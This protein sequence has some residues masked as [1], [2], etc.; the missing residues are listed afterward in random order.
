LAVGEAE[1]ALGNH[2]AALEALR[3]ILRDDA[4]HP[5][6]Y[7]ARI[8]AHEVYLEQEKFDDARKLLMENL[9]HE[10]LTPSSLEW[11]DSLFAL[12]QLP[13]RRGVTLEAAS[14]QAGVDSEDAS[15]RKAGLKTLEEGAAAFH[16]GALRLTEALERYGEAPQAREARYVLAEC[17]R[18]AAKY[19][20]KRIPTIAIE[21][22]R[23]A[24][25]RQ[26]QVELTKAHALYTKTIEDLSALQD[27]R[28]LAQR[29]REVL[30]NC[31]FLAADALFDAGRYEEAIDA[32]SDASNRYQDSPAAMEAFVQIASC[33]RNLEE[34]GKARGT[35]EQA[36][37]MLRRI[38]DTAEFTRTTRF[39]RDEWVALLDFLSSQ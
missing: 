33:Y 14:R 37:V 32:Y 29:E 9:D 24:L 23:A 12:G 13:Y 1:L 16:E 17:Y 8:V 4:K 30:R 22:T 28:P 7:R 36:K 5:L 25:T 19:P 34:P 20:R 26:V 10:A 38:P 35:L 27:V 21:T 6:S 18:Q 2:D 3:L 31:Y 15:L 39:G 11:R